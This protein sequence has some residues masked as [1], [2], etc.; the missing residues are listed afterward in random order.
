M[1]LK[2]LVDKIIFTDAE[3]AKEI[4]LNL[5][6][7]NYVIFIGLHGIS[8]YLINDNYRKAV[9]N[10]KFIFCDSVF[11]QLI[12]MI[13]YKKIPKKSPGPDVVNLLIKNILLKDKGI[14]FFGGDM[15]VIKRIFKKNN[16]SKFDII[17]P[18]LI[19][20]NN[21]SM[22]NESK[23]IL[24]LKYK[25]V[26]VAISC[27]KQEMIASNFFPYMH[28]KIVIPVGAAINF[29]FGIEKR[30]PLIFRKLGLEFIWRL[31]LSP[32]KMSKRIILSLH[33]IFIF[34][35]KR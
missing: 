11:V 21:I 4:I 20:I 34:L 19:D 8:E 25:Y 35:I 14:S 12:Y 18:G 9:D 29:Y 5:K 22:C 17:N 30:A 26:F 2:N 23:K 7:N 16:Y 33:R 28:G 31:V 32:L 10:S 1:L 15:K 27:P 13:L 6:P 24:K 3:K